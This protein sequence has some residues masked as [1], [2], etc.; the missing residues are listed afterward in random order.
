MKLTIGCGYNYLPGYINIDA[1]PESAADRL[2]PAHS[3]AFPDASAREVKAL[4]LVEHL[5]F[6]KTKYFLAE[7]WR[8]LGPEGTLLL[9]TPD[10]EK[11]FELF[12]EGDHKVKEA[13]L[14]WLY[15]SET[16]DMSHLYCFPAA[17]LEELLAEAGFE[18][19]ARETF[20]F[21]PCRPAVRL[22]AV[23]KIK[24][25]AALN[26]VLRHRLVEKGVAV[27]NDELEAAGL[28]FVIRRLLGCGGD[29]AGSLELALYSAPA[30]LE[31]FSLE[32]E[33]EHHPSA[34]AAACSRLCGAGLQAL[35]MDGLERS[36]AGGEV[37]AELFAAAQARGRGLLDTALRGGTFAS[38][39]ELAPVPGVFT[40]D[41]ARAYFAKKRALRA[42][43]RGGG[44]R[45][46]E[47]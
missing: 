23:R 42:R 10:I 9:E 1:L 25:E 46:L 28:D 11:S 24:E 36:C 29:K 3:L 6:F 40:F 26:A 13:V 43:G 30:V 4:Q 44:G 47:R 45:V 19:S 39:A 2:M 5:G 18:V 37:T 33:N 27:F 17:L 8:I 7:C 14:G 31:F 12:L 32:E 35:L 20:D 15:G 38:A 22:K 16:P 41:A 21:Q 34:E